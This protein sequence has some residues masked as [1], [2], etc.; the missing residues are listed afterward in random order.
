MPHGIGALTSEAPLF[1]VPV[2]EGCLPRAPLSGVAGRSISGPPPQ[3]RSAVVAGDVPPLAPSA[4]LCCAGCVSSAWFG[5][6][7]LVPSPP[8]HSCTGVATAPFSTS[9]RLPRPFPSPVKWTQRPTWCPRA[10]AV[11]PMRSPT[12]SGSTSRA[13]SAVRTR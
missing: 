4:L 9:L 13:R 3:G 6:V 7:V 1:V 10:S 11:L 12:G 8:C 5:V 2:R